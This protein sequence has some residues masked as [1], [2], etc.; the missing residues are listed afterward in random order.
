MTFNKILAMHV[1]RWRVF[2]DNV[3]LGLADDVWTMV[4]SQTR[5]G[6]RGIE[7]CHVQ[8]FNKINQ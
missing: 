7:N 4:W 1:F 3:H 6:M 2:G 5:L 8:L